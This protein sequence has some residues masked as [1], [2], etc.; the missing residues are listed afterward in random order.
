MN[1]LERLIGSDRS[2]YGV[3]LSIILL[4]IPC[5]CLGFVA[6][7]AAPASPARA[8]ASR[9]STPAAS[10]VA[11]TVTPRPG[12]TPTLQPT[13][14]PSTAT[15][16]KSPT[17]T[18]TTAP[19]ATPT[20]MLPLVPTLEPIPPLLP[21]D[22]P[23]IPQPQLQFQ[24]AELRVEACDR[25]YSAQGTLVNV[26]GP[27]ND[28]TNVKLGYEALAGGEFLN[29]VKFEPDSWGTIGSGQK[30]GY[31]VSIMT[32]R[33]WRRRQ[34][35]EMRLRLF[36]ASQDNAPNRP[37]AQAIFVVINNCKGD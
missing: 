8:S 22:T 9:T 29:T 30:V 37:P 7:A 27:G 20:E 13:A 4:T 33:E 36:V 18:P 17:A 23:V 26:A 15:P 11:P 28:A 6:L 19:A 16:T 5:Y 1:T 25:N 2:V 34:G 32:N 12:N 14:V 10:A 3:L 31:K 21:T 24:P 35:L